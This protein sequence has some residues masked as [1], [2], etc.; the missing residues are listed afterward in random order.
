MGLQIGLLPVT[1]A[2]RGGQPRRSG[3]IPPRAAAP[4]APLSVEAGTATPHRGY[5]PL[6]GIHAHSMNTFPRS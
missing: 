4:P 5:L 6:P 3:S 1:A 2:R